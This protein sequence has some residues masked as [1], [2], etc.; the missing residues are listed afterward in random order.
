MK[1]NTLP[2]LYFLEEK[3]YQKFYNGLKEHFD[4]YFL[5]TWIYLGL[6]ILRKQG[7]VV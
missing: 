1:V 5:F 7:T 2:Y 3:I 4:I 6:F